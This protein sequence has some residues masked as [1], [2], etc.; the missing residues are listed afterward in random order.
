MDHHLF[1][2]I[3]EMEHTVRTTVL[4]YN[5]IFVGSSGIYLH[6]TALAY[7]PKTAQQ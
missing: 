5:V 7:T 6:A 2:C 4:A 3:E 1:V